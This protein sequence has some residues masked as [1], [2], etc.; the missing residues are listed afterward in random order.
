MLCG[1]CDYVCYAGDRFKDLEICS[2]AVKCTE[3]GL[4]MTTAIAIEDVRREVKI[5]RASSSGAPAQTV[6][7]GEQTYTSSGEAQQSYPPG[8]Q[9]QNSA[10]S[11]SVPTYVYGN[12][13]TSNALHHLR[14]ILLMVRMQNM[15]ISWNWD[16]SSRVYGEATS[17]SCGL[18]ELGNS[19][20]EQIA[21]P[22]HF[23]DYMVYNSSHQAP[24]IVTVPRS[25][26]LCAKIVKYY[27]L[28]RFVEETGKPL[29]EWAPAYD[30]AN[31]CCSSGFQAVMLALGVCEKAFFGSKNLL[32][33]Y[34]S[35]G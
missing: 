29:Q 20:E 2:L 7:S 8:V 19:K 28:K 3:L 21:Q 33:L 22:V 11:P 18:G 27:S 1:V 25:D 13:V 16:R 5:L 26:M 35:E 17:D 6:S 4:T 24:L 14:R 30:G 31:F 32:Q 23:L 9:S 15:R 34:E 10:P 12:F